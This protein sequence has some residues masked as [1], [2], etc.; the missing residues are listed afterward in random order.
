MDVSKP[1]EGVHIGFA[2]CG[3]F[4]TFSTI[5][6]EIEKL[7]EAGAIV[8][9]IFS[10][11]SYTTDTRFGSAEFWIYKIESICNK[12]VWYT[13]AQTEPIGPKAL[14]DIV[15]V[16]PCTGNTI[17]KL[18]NGIADT[19]VT[20]ACKAHLRNNRPV[21]VA[22][23]TNDGLAGAARNIGE[24]QVR[25]NYYFV[26]YGQDDPNGKPCSLVAKMDKIFEA[27]VCALDGKQ[28][29]PVLAN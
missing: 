21:L 25:K 8:Q 12:S 13:V 14:L 19:S 28:L 7:V 10:Y 5:V 27:T 9:P 4:C 16:A 18:A 2:I 1:L 26:P 24:L 6:Q 22:I 15:I 3:S 11:N 29:Q 20:M 23:S 17:A